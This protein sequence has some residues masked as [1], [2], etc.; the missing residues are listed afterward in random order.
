MN[1]WDLGTISGIR[2]RVHWT[3][4][5]LPLYVYFSSLFAG[6][7]TIAAAIS[8]LFVLAIFGCV[9]LHELGHA[10]AARQF[11]IGTRDITLLPIG[12]VAALERMPKQPWQE[13]WIAV[14]GP[15]VN[16]VIA[17]VLFSGLALSFGSPPGIF[18]SFLVQL[19]MANIVLVVFNLIP[20]FPMDGGRVLRS[21][22]AMYL[23]F[24]TATRVAVKVG[25]TLAVGFGL[26]GLFSGNF[27]L[28]LLAMFVYFAAHSE[29]SQLGGSIPVKPQFDESAQAVWIHQSEPDVDRSSAGIW[30]TD[31]PVA[32]EVTVP[33]TLNASSV[34]AWLTSRHANV[35]SVIDSGRVLGRITRARVLAACA[36]G[37]GNVP[38]GRLL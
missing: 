20:A 17:T 26:F 37:Y 32:E 30:F 7:G 18:R 36:Q 11:G 31:Q 12:G 9:L 16:V 13:L 14:A 1:A 15:L 4:L 28:V 5:L 23:D 35:C 10:L 3:F 34:S 19:A 8:I 27:M 2:I 24:G 6:S 21:I 33:S 29:Q 22:L 38:I 25:K